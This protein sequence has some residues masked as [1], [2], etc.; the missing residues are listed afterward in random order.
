V[1]TGRTWIK[2]AAPYRTHGADMKS[3]ARKFL[4]EAGP[5]RLLWGSDWP[6]TG[7][8]GGFSYRDTIDWFKDWI[9]EQDIRDQIGR[10]GLALHG[11]I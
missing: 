11:F 3:L 2:L 5:Q 9:P 7:H 6:W 10:T 1:Q 8:E 4:S